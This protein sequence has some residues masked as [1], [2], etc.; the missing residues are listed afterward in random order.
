M[1]GLWQEL[2]FP[3]EETRL[4]WGTV[5]GG[6][7]AGGRVGGCLRPMGLELSSLLIPPQGYSGDQ[8]YP[9]FIELSLYVLALFFFFFSFWFW[10][11]SNHTFHP[12]Q[13]PSDRTLLITPFHR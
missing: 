7:G 13:Y 11:C 2:P 9:T 12:Q 6:E 1:G 8:Y 3:G 10:F 5:G 4:D